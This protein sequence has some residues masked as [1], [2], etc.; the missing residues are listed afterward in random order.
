MMRTVALLLMTA[1]ALSAIGQTM[2]VNPNTVTGTIS[3][4]SSG[5]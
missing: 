2:D 1:C 5:M 3:G 4:L